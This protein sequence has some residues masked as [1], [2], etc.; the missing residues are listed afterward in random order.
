MSSARHA[1]PASPSTAP[2]KKSSST[3]PLAPALA[4]SC[5]RCS[6]A[7]FFVNI[8]ANPA[9]NGYFFQ[10]VM[11]VRDRWRAPVGMSTF[12]SDT[13]S[14]KRKAADCPFFSAGCGARNL[15]DHRTIAPVN[16]ANK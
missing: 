3:P 10:I 1:L 9:A 15:E 11:C 6:F 7:E 13:N 2:P 5:Q 14:S 16:K 12:F 8:S 4:R